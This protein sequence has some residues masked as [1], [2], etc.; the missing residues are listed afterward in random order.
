[1]NI[2][3]LQPHQ[4][5]VV[6]QRNE[7]GERTQKLEAEIHSEAFAKLDQDEQIRMHRQLA[8]QYQLLSTLNE[9][10]NAF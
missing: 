9:R 10:I 1:M 7:L 8:Q 6:S 2:K 4:Q 3:T 5:L